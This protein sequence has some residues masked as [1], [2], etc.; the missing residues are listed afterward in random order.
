[1]A[2]GRGSEDGNK[3]TDPET[4]T[5]VLDAI[6][7]D[8]GITSGT[9]T[10]LRCGSSSFVKPANLV[11]HSVLV[12]NGGILSRNRTA[13]VLGHTSPCAAYLLFTPQPCSLS[14]LTGFGQGEAGRTLSKEVR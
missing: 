10:R 2:R 14:F 8:K 13:C 5:V 6:R 12:Y 4:E 1:M 9:G 3:Q 7:Q 11:G